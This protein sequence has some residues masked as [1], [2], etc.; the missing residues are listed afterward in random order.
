MMKFLSLIPLLLP[1]KLSWAS[2]VQPAARQATA[3][4]SAASVLA[5]TPAS[6]T[7]PA[8]SPSVTLPPVGSIPRDF[9]HQGWEELW[10]LVGH[11]CSS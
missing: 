10:S 8:A 3:A 9:S 7:A 5:P 6:P 11:F 1:A 2:V 4:A